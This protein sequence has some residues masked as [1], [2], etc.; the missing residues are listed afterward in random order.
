MGGSFGTTHTSLAFNVHSLGIDDVCVSL[1]LSINSILLPINTRG[2][3]G[4]EA[5]QLASGLTK[6]QSWDLNPGPPFKSRGYTVSNS[7][8][9]MD[10]ASLI[11]FIL[12]TLN[13]FITHFSFICQV[14]SLYDYLPLTLH[15]SSIQTSKA[16]PFLLPGPL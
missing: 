8:M 7:I 9:N 5:K 15:S 4:S 1:S 12:D 3:M 16:N 13:L 14:F 10:N 2:E 11:Q 6:R